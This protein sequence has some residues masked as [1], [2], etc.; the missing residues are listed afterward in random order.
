MLKDEYEQHI[1]DKR[2]LH[3][4]NFGEN[5][6]KDESKEVKEQDTQKTNLDDGEV[7][8]EEKKKSELDVD[9][10]EFNEEDIENL[11]G[12]TVNKETDNLIEPKGGDNFQSNRNESNENTD[13]VTDSEKQDNME[14]KVKDVKDNQLLLNEDT[15]SNSEEKP[16]STVEQK[17]SVDDSLSQMHSDQDGETEK[18][19]SE[20]SQVDDIKK[21]ENPQNIDNKTL[22]F[23]NKTKEKDDGLPSEVKMAIDKLK[24]STNENFSS[25]TKAESQG[26]LNNQLFLLTNSQN[27]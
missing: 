11:T 16:L 27:N 26:D 6:N 15:D 24:F 12:S 3:G 18:P 8:N 7:T 17:P 20:N 21:Q 22:S 1:E 10:T 25:N 9:E 14:P 19:I 23:S 13:K 2:K 4:Q 5:R